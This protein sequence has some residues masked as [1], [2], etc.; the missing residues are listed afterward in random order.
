[1]LLLLPSASVVC[2]LLCSALPGPF[3]LNSCLQRPPRPVRIVFDKAFCIFFFLAVVC[4][5]CVPPPSP[6]HL[7]PKCLQRHCLPLMATGP[8]T[9][10]IPVL[11]TAP[12]CVASAS[13]FTPTKCVSHADGGVW[14]SCPLAGMMQSACVSVLACSV[15]GMPLCCCCCCCMLSRNQKQ[16]AACCRCCCLS[17]QHVG[18]PS[19]VL[20]GAV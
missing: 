12:Q 19:L 1:M 20:N 9:H 14:H 10:H 3:Y 7:L 5:A 17:R 16:Q 11:S 15:C 13:C 8:Y 4:P 2:L 18:A 6:S